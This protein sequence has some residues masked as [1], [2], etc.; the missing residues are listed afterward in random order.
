MRKAVIYVFTGTGN[1]RAAADEIAKALEER[2]YE[3]T[4]W[5]ARVP[6]SSAPDPND[7][8][9]AGFGYPI[10]AFNTPQFFLRFAKTLPEAHAKPAFIFK[11]S[12]EPFHLNSASSWP[13][14]RILRRKGFKPM[15]DRHLL[16][17]YNIMFRYPEALARQMILHTRGMAGVIADD[18]AG[19]ES[20]KT[21]Y[22]PWTMIVLYI[23]RLQWFGAWINGPFIRAKKDLCNG[24]GLCV[25]MCPAHNIRME[26]G[27]PR[28]SYH[29]T[30]CMSCAFR[31]PKDA[32][33]PGFL[34]LWRV[35]GAYP[36]EKLAGDESL[37]AAYV[38]ENTKGYFKL[39]RKY[40]AR[41]GEEISAHRKEE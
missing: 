17:P 35:N 37:P 9:V 3:T 26:D 19:G 21:R 40:Y 38:D 7:Y 2:G 6:F 24:C 20:K 15:M 13:L 12:G 8:D 22:Y 36:F 1:T 28:F 18:V 10:H 4:V 14:V 5:E 27:K 41:T 33:R 34:N 25:R 30:M 23:F 31:C 11:T 16:M 39:F 32:V 29:C